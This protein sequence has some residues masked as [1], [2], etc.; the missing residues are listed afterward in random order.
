VLPDWVSAILTSKVFV[1]LGIQA[2]PGFVIVLLAVMGAIES[3]NTPPVLVTTA[4]PVTLESQK[5]VY[6]PA[7]PTE[8]PL[9]DIE[10]LP[11]ATVFGCVC[12]QVLMEPRAHVIEAITEINC[13]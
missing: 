4:F 7:L 8:V 5:H 2:P 13:S 9:P 10:K 1:K 6:V 12:A 11:E 3:E